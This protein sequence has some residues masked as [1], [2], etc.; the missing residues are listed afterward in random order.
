[1]FSYVTG[2]IFLSNSCERIF[3]DF[4]LANTCSPALFSSNIKRLCKTKFD[5]SIRVKRPIG[6]RLLPLIRQTLQNGYAE[7][8]FTSME[9][10]LT[11]YTPPPA[12]Q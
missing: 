8:T 9:R 5:W 6:C 3:N 11:N 2:F 12:K 10:F 1:M 4:E 7:L